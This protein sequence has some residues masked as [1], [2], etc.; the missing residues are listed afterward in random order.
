M[1][2]I[3]IFSLLFTS[4]FSK[5]LEM[6]KDFLLEVIEIPV[7]K[8][9]FPAYLKKLCKKDTSC[10]KEKILNIKTWSTT[11]KDKKLA[12]LLKRRLKNIE[13]NDE[14]FYKIQNK[15]LK[16]FKN[17]KIKNKQYLS[18]VDLSKQVL[19]L[20][21]YEND[22]IKYIG[23]DL[24]STGDMY[25]EREIIFG[26]NHYFNTP[27]GLFKAHRGWRSVGDLG[28]DKVSLGYGK[29]GRYIFYFGK[30]KSKRFNTFRAN[31]TKIIN[32]DKWSII[33]DTLQLA[34]HAHE[35]SYPKGKA[36]SHGCIRLNNETNIFLDNNLFLHKKS[37]INNSWKNPYSH[38]PKEI[39]Y[40]SYIG[41]YLLIEE[42]F[43]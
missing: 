40:S 39:K 30:Q 43:N 2:F 17:K 28:S 12:K 24:V 23:S 9:R 20:V 14:Y 8:K 31:K 10:L 41:Q 27:S 38:A 1:K 19:I 3:L 42:N 34:M 36:Y 22:S 32:E 13:I 16:I 18:I 21:V 15:V 6:R 11:P 7:Y 33:N 5:N 4:L 25:R 29:K 37:I 35:S 26:E